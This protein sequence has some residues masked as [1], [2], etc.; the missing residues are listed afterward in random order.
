MK[1]IGSFIIFISLLSVPH[2]FAQDKSFPQIDSLLSKSERLLNNKPDSALKY[3]FQAAEISQSKNSAL[4]LAR[5]YLSIGRIFNKLN[6][7]DNEIAY[8]QKANKAA[9]NIS[10]QK[11]KTLITISLSEALLNKGNFDDALMFS[12]KAKTMAEKLNDRDLL[13][14]IYFLKGTIFLF[15]EERVPDSANYYYN[16]ALPIALAKKDTSEIADTYRRL[17]NVYY[18]QSQPDEAM[19]Y[20]NKALELYIKIKDIDGLAQTYKDLG[21]IYWKTKDNKKAIE[22]YTKA[23]NTYKDRN[24]VAGTSVGACDLAYMYALDKKKDLLDKYAEESFSLAKKTKSWETIRYSTGWLSEAYELVGNTKT[25]LAYFKTYEA[26]MD[27]MNDRKRI[28]KNSRSQAELNYKS[29]VEQLKTEEEKRQAIADEKA[30]NQKIIRNILIAGFI[31]SFILLLLAYNS[32]VA[33]KKANGIITQQKKEVEAQKVK[34]EE[35]NKEITDSINYAKFIQQSI[36]PDPKEIMKIFP[37]SFGL[38][39]PKDVV[40]GD[41]YW[42]A[43]SG[44]I[45]MIAAADCTGHGVP[46][47]LMSM[48]GVD[49]LNQAVANNLTDPSEIL[50]FVNTEVKNTLKQN[51]GTQISRDGMDIALCCFDLSKNSLKYAGANRPLWIIREGKLTEYKPTK[52]AIGGFTSTEQK[53]AVNEIAL[54]KNDSIYIST[55]GYAD[56]FGGGKGKKMMTKN[57]KDLLLSIQNMPILEQEKFLDSK[58]KSW[59]GEFEQVDDILVIGIQI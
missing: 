41:F 55:D 18:A 59:Q 4:Y 8:K 33:K 32:Y 43:R 9:E 28:E 46:G 45:G 49:K 22:Y 14:K 17:N 21:N 3:S 23:Y 7:G 24:N 40:S 53:F 1:K 13:Y 51:E 48:I 6:D 47:A 58:F 54:Q 35:K 56:Q 29:K 38:Y 2:L 19:N 39:K 15:G 31:I 44:N 36:L 34:I 5:S 10:D 12:Q 42:F 16:K 37:N 52:A 30:H 26:A 27:S 25:A 57:L 20:L 50:S 11:L